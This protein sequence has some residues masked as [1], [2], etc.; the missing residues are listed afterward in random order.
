MQELSIAFHERFES[1]RLQSKVLRDVDVI[2]IMLRQLMNIVVTGSLNILFAMIAT[3][4]QNWF[5]ALFYVVTIPI[6]TVLLK[7]FR[8]RMAMRNEE[9]RNQIEIMSAR[10]NEMVQMIPIARAHGVENAEINHID[11]HLDKV[12]KK[13]IKLDVLN[14]I[15]GASAWVTYQAFQFI[16]LLVTGIMAYKK[17]IPVG[18]VVMYQGFF[19]LIINSV[20]MIINIYPELNRGFDSI[21]SLGE[22][23]ECPDIEDNEGKKKVQ[24]VKGDITFKNVWFNYDAGNNVI[25]NFS[26]EIKQGEC[27]AF[28][29]E[30]GAGKS[31]LISLLIGY[32]RPVKGEIL[33]DGT[34]MNELDLRSYRRFISVVPQNIFLY[35]GTIR[36]NILYGLDHDKVDEKQFLRVTELSRVNEFVN[37]LPDGFDT[38]IGEHGNK[39]SGGQ[40][41]R[42]AIARALIRDPQI[43]IFDEATSALD[44]NSEHLIQE[45]ISGM[46]KERTTF[47][48]AHRLST[49]K[50]AD[51]IV[52]IQ[53]GSIAE[54]GSH[55]ELVSSKGIY[56]NMVAM[57][58]EF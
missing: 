58:A 49:I 19:A 20:N 11:N 53:K 15:F 29:G 22:I 18:D 3:L 46:I 56:S 4:M 39:M 21:R 2:E 50:M 30:S 31:T 51:K 26:L 37:N 23:L 57:Q 28:V 44:V 7:V 48:I 54:I 33:L 36:E 35:S 13:G 43:L 14:A 16:C 27:V 9:Y 12:K 24:Q 55:Y 38:L 6:S 25:S 52:V 47:M 34:N 45:A 17:I 8:G 32:R 40:K 10:L 41:Q 5:V 1:G 42:I